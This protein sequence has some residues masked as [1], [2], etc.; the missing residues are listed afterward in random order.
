MRKVCSCARV[1][2][3]VAAPLGG[4]TTDL[5]LKILYNLFFL[6]K[7]QQD[8]PIQGLLGVQNFAVIGER[9]Q[10]RCSVLQRMFFS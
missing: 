4:A 9:A 8:E 1:F 6:P 5:K 10:V 3:F 7:G 2:N